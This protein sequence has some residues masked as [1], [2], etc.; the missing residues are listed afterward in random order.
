MEE[1]Y[2]EARKFFN[3]ERELGL[4]KSSKVVVEA[5][6]EKKK[7]RIRLDKANYDKMINK[8]KHFMPNHRVNGQWFENMRPF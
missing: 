6:L 4:D 8:N 5:V 1:D 7:R 2:G 3:L